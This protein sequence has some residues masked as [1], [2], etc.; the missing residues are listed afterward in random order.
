MA[1]FKPLVSAA[2][3]LPAILL[4]VLIGHLLWFAGIHGAAIVSGMLQM[5]WLTNLGMNQQALAQGA[6]LPHIFMEAFWTFFIVVGG[7]G[8]TMGLVFCYLRSRSAHLRSIGRLSVV[9]SL[10]NINEPVIF[11]TPIVMN[12]VFFI[13][14][15]LAPMVNAGTG[16]GGNEAGSDWPRHLRSTMDGASANWRRLG[17]GL[18]FPGGDSGHCSGLR[19]GNH[20]LPIL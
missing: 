15:L 13:P 5:F 7:S 17:V 1:I 12:P 3:S 18:G 6:P 8:A 4:A 14:F 10:F 11:G 20:L 16:L 9:P 2:D 19:V